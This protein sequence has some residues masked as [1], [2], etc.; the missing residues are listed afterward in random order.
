MNLSETNRA[1]ISHHR[2][3]ELLGRGGIGMSP[4]A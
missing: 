2:L 4:Q 1:T 3:L